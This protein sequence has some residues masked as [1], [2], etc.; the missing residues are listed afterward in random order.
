M[1]F[2]QASVL[3]LSMGGL[4]D[5]FR[6]IRIKSRYNLIVTLLCDIIYTILFMVASFLFI[7]EIANGIIHSYI[8]LGIVM[9]LCLYFLSVSR[10]IVKC[11]LKIINFIN[12]MI[13][14]IIKI[15]LSPFLWIS[16]KVIKKFF[17]K[18]LK[19]GFIFCK[20]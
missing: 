20:K 12:S 2:L 5:F 10:H 4:Y 1:I 6:L 3:G 13:A 9:G 16:N 17:K 11:S 7:I 14:K 19:K 8:P 18:I 15:A